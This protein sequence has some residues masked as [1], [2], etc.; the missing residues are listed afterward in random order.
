MNVFVFGPLLMTYA[1]G[2]KLTQWSINP[3][4][5]G[6]CYDEVSDDFYAVG[7]TW[8]VP[9]ICEEYSCDTDEDNQFL[10][11]TAG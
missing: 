5:P 4:H 8:N 3:G 11:T 2:S 1:V 6:K 9:G 7:K 10:I